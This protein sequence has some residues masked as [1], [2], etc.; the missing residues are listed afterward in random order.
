[1]IHAK[2]SIC[3]IGLGYVGLTVSLAF[4]NKK[5]NVYGY[6][7]DPKIID[8][9]LKGNS[10]IYEKNIDKI[11]KL[12]LKNNFFKPLKTIPKNI[13]Y[14]IVTVGT[15]L[16]G[17]K[18]DLS[19]IKNITLRLSKIL[20]DRSIVI[21]RS[22]LPIGTLREYILPKLKKSK[23]INVCFA[24]ERTIEGDAINELSAIPQII[25]TED[26]YTRQKVSN[27]F[28]KINK[29]IIY[30]NNF[31]E[32]EMIKLINNTYR[33]LSF[34]FSN[35]LAMI[36]A[37]YQLPINRTI[38]LANYDYP[39]NLVPKASMGVG[40]PCLTKDPFILSK[41][42]RSKQ[43][44]VFNIGRKINRDIL[45]SCYLKLKAKLNKKSKILLCGLAFKGF[46]ITKDVRGSSSI[47]LYKKFSKINK[48][49]VFDP[50][51]TRYELKKYKI[52]EINYKFKY[53]LV[54]ICNNSKKIKNALLKTN[55]IQMLNKNCTIFDP[56]DMFSK[57]NF[58]NFNYF[59]LGEI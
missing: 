33:D 58:K 1:M 6:D 39:R 13:D 43:N 14:Y 12:N 50:I 59:R 4:A 47:Y 54:V 9:L 30:S 27:L 38:D 28:K 32:G 34:A 18:V 35:Q 55:F 16:K 46:P 51:F 10:H 17:G 57:K 36:A 37:K 3:V 49:Y 8:G 22:T 25:C 52:N 29:K 26:E 44:S 42:L 31:E 48:T 45:H 41:S 19:H 11:L 7:K 2:S 5:L 56:W 20:N 53:D 24:P 21:Y 23:H 15:P 40:G